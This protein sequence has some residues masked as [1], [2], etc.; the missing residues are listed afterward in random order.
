MTKCVARRAFRDSR[1]PHGIFH[2]SLEHGLV[3]VMAATLA[4]HAVDVEARSRKHPLPRPFASSVRILP[5]Q[6][7]RQVDPAGVL[8]EIRFVVISDHLEMS[9]EIGLHGCR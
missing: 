8:P 1:S 9:G 3:E 5:G 2:G 7:P 4:G 6:G